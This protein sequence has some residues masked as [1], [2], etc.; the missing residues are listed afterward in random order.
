[1]IRSLPTRGTK[2]RTSP[3]PGII[4]KSFRFRLIARAVSPAFLVDHID[5]SD[6]F[7]VASLQSHLSEVRR[8]EV[9]FARGETEYLTIG[10][11]KI[12]ARKT[13]T[14]HCSSMR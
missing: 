9:S 8:S 4:S 1:M 2:D 13:G 5:L 12:E 7:A 14:A 6:N 3:H 10:P 11:R